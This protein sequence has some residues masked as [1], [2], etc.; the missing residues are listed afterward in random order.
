[1]AS[2]AQENTLIFLLGDLFEVW[3]G[4]DYTDPVTT[5][6]AQATRGAVSCGAKVFFMH[7]NRDFLLGDAF[8]DHAEIEILP[9]PEFLSVGNT[10]V[11]LSH[12]DQFC[13]DDKAYQKFRLE[14]RSEAWQNNFLALP[15]QQRIAIA[16]AMRKESAMHKSTSELSIMDVNAH[17]VE[18]T[19]KGRWPDGH[20]IGKNGVIVHGHTHRPAVHGQANKPLAVPTQSQEGELTDG[21]R[22]VLPDWDFDQPSANHHKGGFLALS[23]NRQFKLTIFN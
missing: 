1:M 13:T 9:D 5:R 14:S 8:A 6:F 23:P 16:K 19:F 10:V 2:V 3:Y 11:L 7:G 20:F 17:A 4:D 18:Q 22:I 12:G 21:Q 15:L